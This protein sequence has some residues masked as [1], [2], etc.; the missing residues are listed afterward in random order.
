MIIRATA[1]A[2]QPTAAKRKAPVSDEDRCSCDPDLESDWVWLDDSPLQVE[3]DAL[4]G[5]GLL[6][7]L[8]IEDSDDALLRARRALSALDTA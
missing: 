8:L 2:C 1:R 7:R 4:R 3:I 6:H 5:L